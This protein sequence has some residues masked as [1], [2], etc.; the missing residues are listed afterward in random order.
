MAVLLTIAPSG[1]TL[2]S[3]PSVDDYVMITGVDFTGAITLPSAPFLDPLT[4]G[5]YE[6][7][8]DPELFPG[9]VT[10]PAPTV[11]G[12]F[13]PGTPKDFDTTENGVSWGAPVVAGVFSRQRYFFGDITLPTFSDKFLV[14]SP[15]VDQY[16][17]SP[18]SDNYVLPGVV[19]GEYYMPRSF[20]GGITLPVITTSALFSQTR[21]FNGS[22]TWSAPVV[23]G[24]WIRKDDY[25]GALT[26][27]QLT[28]SGTISIVN[29]FNGTVTWSAP[30]IAAEDAITAPSFSTFFSIMNQ[31]NSGFGNPAVDAYIE[32]YWPGYSSQS[33]SPYDTVNRITG[34]VQFAASNEK[35]SVTVRA[36]EFGA[37]RALTIKPQR[38]IAWDGTV[39]TYV[40][41]PVLHRLSFTW[42][43]L[44]CNDAEILNV[45]IGLM[46]MEEVQLVYRGET[47]QGVLLDDVMTLI[48]A[49]RHQ[50]EITLNFEGTLL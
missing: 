6:I 25:I 28:T 40:V 35:R 17:S 39:R 37:R 22:A 48:D 19:F 44:G 21:I 50:S 46:Y 9:A 1:D 14:S 3:T 18:S 41:N 45:F 27:P 42:K 13:G 26:L 2:T 12:L 8:A 32:R 5:V 33:A 43:L 29:V 38:Q 49:A 23:A 4:R 15:S 47:F 16:I 24:T 31:N 10:L 36:P 11:A 34:E 30:L 20:A 7:E